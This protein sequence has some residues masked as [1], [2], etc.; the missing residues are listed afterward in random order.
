MFT[1]F[2]YPIFKY[3]P[4]KL[5]FIIHNCGGKHPNDFKSVVKELIE[6]NYLKRNDVKKCDILI[7]GFQEIVEMKGKN[8]TNIVTNYNENSVK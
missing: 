5:G 4:A 8:L 7:I 1:K 6:V 2:N 3:K